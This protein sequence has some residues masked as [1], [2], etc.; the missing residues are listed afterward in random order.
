MNSPELAAAMVAAYQK[1]WREHI[2]PLEDPEGP[3]LAAALRV[4]VDQVVPDEPDYMRAAISDTG[5]WDKHDLIRSEL[6]ALVA[7]LEALPN[8]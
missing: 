6:F 7:A 1:E 2:G 5:W 3:C 8:D 4:M